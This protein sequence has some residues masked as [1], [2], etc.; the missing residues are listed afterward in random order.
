MTRLSSLMYRTAQQAGRNVRQAMRAVLQRL[1]A[2]LA[3]PAAQ[4]TGLDG[5]Q[6]PAELIQHY[7]IASAPLD[8]AE[9]IV[10]PVGV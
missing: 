10:I 5:E 8:G 9:V 1:D 2:T 7:G 6:L 4:L 3:I